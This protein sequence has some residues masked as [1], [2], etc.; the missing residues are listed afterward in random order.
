MAQS[1][2]SIV[3]IRSPSSPTLCGDGKAKDEEESGICD[4]KIP[5]ISIAMSRV[6]ICREGGEENSLKRESEMSVGDKNKLLDI[7]PREC[8]TT[9]RITDPAPSS[10]LIMKECPAVVICGTFSLAPVVTTL[11]LIFTTPNEE[12]LRQSEPFLPLH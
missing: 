10:T 5:L 2:H 12:I 3:G 6:G 4:I 11:F 9:V 1:I 7:A 8:S